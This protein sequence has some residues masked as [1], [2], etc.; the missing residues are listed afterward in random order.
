[1]YVFGGEPG[2]HVRP[3]ESVV[4]IRIRPPEIHRLREECAVVLVVALRCSAAEGKDGSVHLEERL[5][6]IKVACGKHRPVGEA[7]IL[8]PVRSAPAPEVGVESAC[9]ARPVVR[10]HREERAVEFDRVCTA[11]GAGQHVALEV[12]S[13]RHRFCGCLLGG[14][15]GRDDDIA[16]F[17]ERCPPFLV[18]STQFRFA[19]FADAGCFGFGIGQ[20]SSLWYPARSCGA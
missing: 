11:S 20:P 15:G 12:V 8:E 3:V 13:A 16:P 4:G 1:M 5:H 17:P 18:S 19:R 7:G 10:I 9:C 6:H 2:C 14:V